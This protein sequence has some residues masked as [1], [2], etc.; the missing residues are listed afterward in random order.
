MGKLFNR[1]P[2]IRSALGYLTYFMGFVQAFKGLGEV[3]KGMQTGDAKMKMDGALDIAAGACFA[4]KVFSLAGIAIDGA[5][6]ELD[7]AISKKEI[8]AEQGN[9]VAQATVGIVTGPLTRLLH[10]VESHLPWH[11]D[12]KP[13]AETPPPAPPPNVGSLTKAAGIAVGGATGATAG[14][15]IGPYSGIMAG[16]ALAGPVGGVLGLVVGALA[17]VY[18]GSRV[19]GKL[20]GLVGGSI[21]KL[22]RNMAPDAGAPGESKAPSPGKAPAAPSPG[23]APP[24]KDR[25][26][27]ADA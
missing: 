19:G 22:F 26:Q 25:T 1:A 20:G 21:N 27:S 6:M 15:F 23:K 7:R 5:K 3:E 16:F 14:G 9:A 4:S 11:K 18:I 13:P 17:G 2:W 8:T 24:G 12:D 10:W